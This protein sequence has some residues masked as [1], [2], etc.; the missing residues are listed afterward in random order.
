MQAGTQLGKYRRGK[1]AGDA[2][3]RVVKQWVCCL[4]CV[5]HLCLCPRGRAKEGAGGRH[6]Q[7]RR[8]ESEGKEVGGEDSGWLCG[9]RARGRGSHLPLTS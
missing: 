8:G 4:S 2:R 7:H 9:E 5:V 6:D 3:L 1:S